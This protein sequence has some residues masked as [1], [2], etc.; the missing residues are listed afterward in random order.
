MHQ[1]LDENKQWF[2]FFRSIALITALLIGLHGVVR[3]LSPGSGPRRVEH[4]VS[5]GYRIFVLR[6]PSPTT[7]Q[8]EDIIVKDNDDVL[9]TPRQAIRGPSNT[10]R[11]EK[12]YSD[13]TRIQLP[14]EQ[15]QAIDQ[16]RRHWCHAPPPA[17]DKDDP[18]P[19]YEVGFRCGGYFFRTRRIQITEEQIPPVLDQLLTTIPS[20]QEQE[21]DTE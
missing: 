9:S 20:L 18:G 7:G 19:R 13:Y 10:M 11:E 12:L 3:Y 14:P 8:Q 1:I 17:P 16:L 21:E 6:L 4:V 2:R 5:G 15:W